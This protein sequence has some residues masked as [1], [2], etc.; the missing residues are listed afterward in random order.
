VR[1]LSDS[2]LSLN[3]LIQFYADQDVEKVYVKA[4]AANDNSKNQ[5]YFGPGFEALNLFPMGEI[6]SDSSHEQPI[7]KS[8]LNFFWINDN[9]TLV[10][11]PSAQIILYP[12]YPE[13]RFSG[14]LKGAQRTGLDSVR[15]MMRNRTPGRIL[16]LGIAP[17]GKEFMELSAGL[18]KATEVFFELLTSAHLGRGHDSRSSLLMELCRIHRLGWINSKKLDENGNPNPYTASNGGGYTLEAE[19]GIKPNGRSE[20][21]YMDWEVKQHGGS[22]LTL[23]TPEPTGGFYVEHGVEKFIR[24]F[25]Y[26]DRSGV[27]D[28]MNFG[29]THFCNTK[30]R[31]TKLTISLSGYDKVSEKILDVNGGIA[32]KSDDGTTAAFWAFTGIFEHWKRKHNNAVYVPSKHIS[33]LPSRYSFSNLVKLGEGTDPLHLLKAIES[34][35]VYYDPGIKLERM[36]DTH[37][38]TKKRSQFRVKMRDLDKLYHKVT[39]EDVSTHCG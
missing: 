30:N 19:L 36:N 20:P 39:V 16:F 12:Q 6:H 38:R 3:S 26:M 28:R 14:F 1:E 13:T 25:G 2:I 9:L 35:K 11:A 15:K 7:F 23:M 22:V 34:G 5:V 21:D 33:D 8:N 27:A 32:L 31:T 18:T 10:N 29:G 4:L 24:K 37:P 17:E